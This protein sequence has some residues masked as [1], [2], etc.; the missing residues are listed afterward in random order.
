MQ[1]YPI[2][3]NI[4]AESAEEAEEARTALVGFIREHA[5]HGRAVTGKKIADAVSRWDRNP[6]VKHKIVEFFK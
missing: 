1:G 2:T 6:I 3:L 5:K 4:Y